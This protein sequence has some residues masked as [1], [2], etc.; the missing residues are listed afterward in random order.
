MI[1]KTLKET[2]HGNPGEKRILP[3]GI[4]V[5]LEPASNLPDDS[6]IK[7]WAKPLEGYEWPKDTADWAEVGVG[8]YVDDVTLIFADDNRCG[9][10]GLEWM[11]L[12]G[13]RYCPTCEAEDFYPSDFP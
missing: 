1:G 5:N 10:C 11:Y 7:Y 3:A 4:L 9:R 6:P 12:S 2:H 13:Q 8:L